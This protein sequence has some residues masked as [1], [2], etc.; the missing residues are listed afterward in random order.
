VARLEEYL[1]DPMS[2]PDMEK[3]QTNLI[4]KLADER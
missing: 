2:Q 4:F 3:W 1:H